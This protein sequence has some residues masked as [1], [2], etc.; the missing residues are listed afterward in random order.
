M[1]IRNGF[2]SNSSASSFIISDALYLSKLSLDGYSFI[3]LD[4]EQIVKISQSIKDVLAT[5][6]DLYLTEY[7]SDGGDLFYEL[8]D[9]CITY[10]EGNHGNPYDSENFD[11]FI[12]LGRQVWIKKKHNISKLGGK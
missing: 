11:T 10:D 7:V 9:N 2:V 8:R 12:V 4:E 5:D 1:K 6:K 3:K